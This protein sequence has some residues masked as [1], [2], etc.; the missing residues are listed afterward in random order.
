[1]QGAEPAAFTSTEH[2]MTFVRVEQRNGRLA[3]AIRIDSVKGKDGPLTKGTVTVICNVR[4][5]SGD[6]RRGGDRATFFAT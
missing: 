3:S 6:A 2:V 1:M 4:R 5:G